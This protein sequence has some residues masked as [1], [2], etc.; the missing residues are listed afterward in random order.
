MVKIKEDK[1]IPT[2]WERAEMARL[3]VEADCLL[4]QLS[5]NPTDKGLID[6]L[7]WLDIAYIRLSG[8][9]SLEY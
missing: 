5:R 3:E 6:R 7:N 8:E 4:E 1:K 2:P 9:K